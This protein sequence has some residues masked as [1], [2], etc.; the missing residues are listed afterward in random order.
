MKDFN[1]DDIFNNLGETFCIKDANRKYL[2][3]NKNFLNILGVDKVDDL[4]NLTDYDL[5][6]R[7]EAEVYREKD[8]FTIKNNRL[9]NSHQIVT[10]ENG[11]HM[12]LINKSLMYENGT[13]SGI[14]CHGVRLGSHPLTQPLL[15]QRERECICYLYQGYS[16]AEIAKELKISVRTVEYHV[17]NLKTKTNSESKSDVLKKFRTLH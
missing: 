10:G 12:I 15:A 11:Y 4:E 7:K 17:E 1:I 5:Y 14:I 3:A 8:K 13:V 9:I 6:K 16:H 2:Y